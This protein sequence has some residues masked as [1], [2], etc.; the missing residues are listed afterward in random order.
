MTCNDQKLIYNFPTV[1]S[2]LSYDLNLT[3]DMSQGTVEFW[4]KK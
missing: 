3:S 1:S 4:Y 2:Y